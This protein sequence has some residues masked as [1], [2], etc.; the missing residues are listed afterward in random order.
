MKT[1]NT[2]SRILR[3][4]TYAAAGVTAASLIAIVGYAILKGVPHLRP[5]MFSLHYSSENASMLPALI[6]TVI[7]VAGTLLIATPLGIGAAVWLTEYAKRGSRFV[8]YVRLAAETLA[9]VPSIVYGLF[10]YLLFNVMLGLSY[11]LLSGILTLCV[12]VLP[13]M[14]R[15][16]EE[17]LR[18][19]PDLWREGSFGLG[20]GKLR[21]VMTIVLPAAAPGILSG[22]I[23]S[24]GRVV[25]ETAAL[26]FTAG[27]A[28]GVASLLTSGRTLSVHMYALLSEGLY[29]DQAN[30]IAPVLLLL[31]I[32]LNALS[33]RAERK[34]RRNR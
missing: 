11:S 31:V 10:G 30:A 22:V 32:L 12:M 6:N 7:V 14:I 29:M 16:T 2:G 19:V 3:F 21:T 25:G 27:T 15:T 4:L 33:R 5:D 18:A 13:T 9:G 1:K 24:I 17:A 20:A 23:L 26:I 28:T 34:L 8:K